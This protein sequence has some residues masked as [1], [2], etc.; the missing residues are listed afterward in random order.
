MDS[1]ITI[2]V[3]RA[4]VLNLLSDLLKLDRATITIKDTGE[5]F[6]TDANLEASTM[7]LVITGIVSGAAASITTSLI[8]RLSKVLAKSVRKNVALVRAQ[9][10][11]KIVDLEARSPEEIEKAILDLDRDG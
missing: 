9:K 8:D 1:S 3:S 2:E 4:H 11:N 5:T 6:N 7:E 10:L